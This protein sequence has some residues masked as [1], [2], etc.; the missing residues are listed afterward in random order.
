M[1]HEWLYR[2]TAPGSERR[3]RS[4]AVINFRFVHRLCRGCYAREVGRPAAS[5]VMLFK[6]MLLQFLYGISG[7]RIVEEV[8]CHMALKWFCGLE[9]DGEP[10]VPPE[11]KNPLIAL[12]FPPSAELF[13]SAPGSPWQSVRV[14]FPSRNF[15]S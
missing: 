15:R 3:S 4:D 11:N 2:G 6:M 12:A 13:I 5:P 8:R 1:A 7:R 10:P 14:S 9:A